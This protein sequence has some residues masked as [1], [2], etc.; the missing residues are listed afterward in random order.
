MDRVISEISVPR[1]ILRIVSYVAELM[2]SRLLK[3]R[4]IRIL[5]GSGVLENVHIGIAA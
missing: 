1:M 2:A 4:P 3:L 5:V